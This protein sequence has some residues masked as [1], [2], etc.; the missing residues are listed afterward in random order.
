M[1]VVDRQRGIFDPSYLSS[2]QLHD[3]LVVLTIGGKQIPLDP[4]EKMCPFQLIQ[5]RHSSASGFMQ[6]GD[7]RFVGS[8]AA[9]PYTENRLNRTGDIVL[10]G[11][12]NITGTLNVTMG[13]QEALFWRQQ[14]LKRDDSAIKRQFERSLKA[15]L[16]EGIEAHF[17][18]FIA[19]DDPDAPLVA[20]VNVKGTMGTTTAKRLMLPGFFFETRAHR[21][22]VDQEKRQT[23]VDMHYGELT[24]DQITYRLP[25]GLAVESAP[26]NSSNLWKDHAIFKVATKTTPGQIVISRTLARAFTF[27]KPEEYQDLRGFFSNVA[28]TDQAQ[29]ILTTTTP[30]KGN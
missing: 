8:T 13:G 5:W 29:L 21:P 20:I 15:Q 24:T 30:V 1:K 19:L 26:P 11:Q 6:S 12:G 14:A 2:S 28:A 17:D 7:G 3:T 9:Q 27:A 4:G 18:H 25:E 22:F 16:P 10:D 23:P